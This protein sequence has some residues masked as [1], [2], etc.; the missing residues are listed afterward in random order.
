MDEREC[1]NQAARIEA[2]IQEVAAFPDQQMRA[3]TEE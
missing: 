2:L 3:R 1:Q